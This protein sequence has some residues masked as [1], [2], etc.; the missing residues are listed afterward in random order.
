MQPDLTSS[1]T[2]R[3]SAELVDHTK[4]RKSTGIQW[5]P[6]QIN[7]ERIRHVGIKNAQHG[8]RAAL[9]DLI[10]NAAALE[11]NTFTL[12]E[13]RNLLDGITVSGRKVEEEQQILALS[14]GYNLVDELVGKS[15]FRLDKET[16]DRVHGLVARHE[17]IESGHFRGEGSVHGGG[18][19]RLTTGG[20]VDGVPQV[21]LQDRWKLLMY[22]LAETSDPRMRALVYNAAATR[23]QYY[24]DGN[25]RTARLMMAGELMA[26]GF[27]AVNIPNSRRLEFNVA[28]DELFQTEDATQLMAFTVFCAALLPPPTYR[29]AGGDDAGSTEPGPLARAAQATENAVKSVEDEFGLLSS[30]QVAQLLGS[31]SNR[32]AVRSLADDMRGRGELLYVR[33]LNK[34]LY[35]GF[36]FNRSLGR[37]K[38]LVKALMQLANASSWEPE[39]V[40]LWLCSPTTY[41]ED[42]SRPVDHFDAEPNQV[43]DVARH[44]WNVEW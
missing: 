7:H 25:K 13:V 32:A 17:A 15:E 18:T 8:F 36:Q 2:G 20:Y 31:T 38:P 6:S 33:R 42:E 30:A 39:D 11:G 21:E 10:W 9:P 40:V 5:D 1:A 29:Q 35:P 26:H 27:D 4:Q 14:E 34:Y 44:A 3:T 41:F 12:H 19:V 16:S 22:H 37:V 28:L 24:F 23:T 43:L